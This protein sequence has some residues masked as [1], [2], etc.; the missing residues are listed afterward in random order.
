[1]NLNI[2]EDFQICISVPLMNFFIKKLPI[3]I[4][5]N[6]YSL[7]LADELILSSHK[8]FLHMFYFFSQQ[9][10]FR[11]SR[12][13]V[14]CKK[15]VLT[16]FAKFTGKHLCQ[17]LFFGKIAGQDSFKNTFFTELLRW[18]LLSLQFSVNYSHA[19]VFTLQLYR[20]HKGSSICG[21]PAKILQNLWSAACKFII[22]RLRRNL[23]RLRS[24]SCY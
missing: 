4:K 15:F 9:S 5:K 6:Q 21:T 24:S 22:L 16:N 14:F 13:E 8:K 7:P 20:G 17:S 19:R 1:M 2:W 11:S 10:H 18:L 3:E 23:H 12:P